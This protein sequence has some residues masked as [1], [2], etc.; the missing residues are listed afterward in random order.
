MQAHAHRH[1]HTLTHRAGEL[2]MQSAANVKP[3]KHQDILG[4]AMFPTDLLAILQNDITVLRQ[5]KQL[6]L[7]TLDKQ[8]KVQPPPISRT[9]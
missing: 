4:I 1:A 3:S 7:K 6:R 9:N 2:Q 5:R 8:R